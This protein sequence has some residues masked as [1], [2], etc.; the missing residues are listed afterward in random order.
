MAPP[1]LEVAY[2]ITTVK[3]KYCRLVD[4]QEWE[5]FDQVMLPDF[6]F[7]IK[8]GDSVTNL[9]TRHDWVTQFTEQL[10]SLQTHHLVGPG[11]LE[12]VSPDEVKAIIP[13]QYLIA[14]KDQT[15]KFRTSG[16]AFYHDIFKRVDGA[17]FLAETEAKQYV[18]RANSSSSCASA[19]SGDTKR[20]VRDLWSKLKSVNILLTLNVGQYLL[21][22]GLI[23]RE[24]WMRPGVPTVVFLAIVII[25]VVI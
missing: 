7:K 17:W 21:H 23:N 5:S 14:H 10:K 13:I 8:Q 25:V 3:A 9:T 18:L 24:R 1:S 2:A 12:E 22:H 11:E 16:G 20:V 15:S 4:T 19:R 6:K